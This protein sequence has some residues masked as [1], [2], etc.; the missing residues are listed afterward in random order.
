MAKATFAGA[1][2][3]AFVMNA[4]QQG[5]H[6]L[7]TLVLAAVLGPEAFGLVAMALVYLEFFQLFLGQGLTAAL[8]QRSHLEPIDLDTAFW[9]VM[10]STLVLAGGAAAT[11]HLWAEFN[12]EPELAAISIGLIPMLIFKGLSVVQ[13]AHLQRQM[14]FQS[15]AIR[16]NVAVAV[17]GV[18]G[19]ALA[20]GGWGAWSLVVQQV[21]TSL[22]EMALLWRFSDFR[23]RARFSFPVARELRSFGYRILLK[24][25]GLFTSRRADALV[26]GYFFGPVALALYRMAERLSQLVVELSTRPVAQVSLPNF[27][28]LKPDPASLRDGVITAVKTS[29]I[30]SIPALVGLAAV[31]DPLIQLLG[32]EWHD[33]APVLR[34]LCALGAARA[35]TLHTGSLLQAV[36]R[37]GLLAAMTWALAAMNVI[38]FTL[39]GLWLKGAAPLEQIRGI[40][41]ARAGIY[42]LL[43]AP[44]YLALLIG[45][46]GVTWRQ[47]LRAVMPSL[48]AG[49]TVIAAVMALRAAAAATGVPL[50]ASLVAQVA[51]GAAAGAATLYAADAEFRAHAGA[52]ARWARGASRR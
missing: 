21:L 1:L 22:V 19:L 36:G 34:I 24:Q 3:W 4:G 16:S 10:A 12:R 50:T 15:L 46:S 9:Q 31:S 20:V 6:A 25:V 41:S 51:L 11:A 2:R 49:A 48:V 43:Y 27:A 40:A 38:G 35:L 18:A 14:D 37:P 39:L 33:S 42:V 47:L 26:L 13:Q 29:A 7:I 23:P 8:I 32:A 17:G 28:R 52:F 5:M 30:L 44:P 45:F